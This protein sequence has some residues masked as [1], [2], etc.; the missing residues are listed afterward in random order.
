VLHNHKSNK[1]FFKNKTN[2]IVPLSIGTKKIKNSKVEYSNLK[3]FEIDEG[4]FELIFL[5]N[6]KQVN[7]FNISIIPINCNHLILWLVESFNTSNHYTYGLLSGVEYNSALWFL[8]VP[9]SK[10]VEIL[11]LSSDLNENLTL[12]KSIF[13]RKSFCVEFLEKEESDGLKYFK[14]TLSK[15]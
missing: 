15:T 7:S 13:L 11:K 8:E 2:K 3:I 12:N 4:K 9:E 6:K 1:N 14:I 10:E 5:I